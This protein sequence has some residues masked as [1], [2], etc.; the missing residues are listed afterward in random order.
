MLLSKRTSKLQTCFWEGAHHFVWNTLIFLLLAIT[1]FL[2]RIH[3]LFTIMFYYIYIFPS[4][5]VF[6]YI[7]IFS[8]LHFYFLCIRFLYFI[9]FYHIY[10][11]LYQLSSIA[12]FKNT[13]PHS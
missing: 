6:Y 13:N 12:K 4:A 3:I 5:I 11:F 9:M 2:L 1:Y 10:A 7:Y 8:L